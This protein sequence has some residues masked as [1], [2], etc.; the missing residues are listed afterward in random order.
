[1]FGET[2]SSSCGVE[3]E[4]AG[5]NF[6][7]VDHLFV[8]QGRFDVVT[9]LAVRAPRLEVAHLCDIHVEEFRDTRELTWREAYGC[10]DA[11]VQRGVLK[12]AAVMRGG[13]TLWRSCVV[14]PALQDDHLRLR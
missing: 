8:P 10:V 5:G 4:T 9:G 13:R 11:A 2:R 7:G 6:G 14:H 1:M 3:A 12:R